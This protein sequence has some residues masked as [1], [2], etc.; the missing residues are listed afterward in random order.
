MSKKVMENLLQDIEELEPLANLN[1]ESWDMRTRASIE[2][3]KKESRQKL[4]ELHAK[5]LKNTLQNAK[6]VFFPM[7][8]TLSQ[9][10]EY[11]QAQ[12][13]ICVDAAVLYSVLAESVERSMGPSREYG[14]LQQI[15]LVTALV[16]ACAPV[17]V[18]SFPALPPLGEVNV[19]PTF[20]DV[21]AHVKNIVRTAIGDELNT[22]H[23]EK[24]I[25]VKSLMSK[26]ASDEPLIVVW[27]TT[28][29]D[30][31]DSLS[32]LLGF[33]GAR[34]TVLQETPKTTENKK[35]KQQQQQQEN[36]KEE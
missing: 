4:A 20:D 5:Y 35:K 36:N 29:Q 31:V 25:G 18:G 8:S 13:G 14:A 7:A 23:L 27:G 19:L 3:T 26:V 28:S 9:A 6:V 24:A 30:E 1:T 12:D 33:S 15:N 22:L 11:A 10:Q 34:S 17:G 2:A 32:K 16:D 21:R